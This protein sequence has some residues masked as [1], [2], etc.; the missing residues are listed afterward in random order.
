MIDDATA[1]SIPTLFNIRGMDDPVKPAITR[2]P[3]IARN[4]T[5]PSIGSA[6]YI[7]A[8]AKTIFFILP[9]SG[10]VRIGD[11]VQRQHQKQHDARHDDDRQRQ[12]GLKAHVL[13]QSR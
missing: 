6:S 4:N 12:S 7:R 2:L 10:L 8:I 3:V 1:G 13:L 11:C 9:P 5:R